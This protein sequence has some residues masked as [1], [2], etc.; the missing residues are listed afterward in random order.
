MSEIVVEKKQI[1]EPKKFYC[2]KDHV[3][4]ISGRIK[5]GVKFALLVLST[6]KLVKNNPRYYSKRGNISDPEQRKIF[7]Q[8]TGFKKECIKG[9]YTIRKTE[10]E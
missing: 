2:T 6:W 10:L 5:K 8:L 4:P 7:Y 1:H 9:I 3:G